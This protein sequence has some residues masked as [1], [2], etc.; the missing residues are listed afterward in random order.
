MPYTAF[1]RFV[2]WCRFR[3]ARPHI[4]PGSR[5]C[6]IG[7]GLDARFLRYLK[8]HIRLGLGL[9]YQPSPRSAN[10]PVVVLTDITSGFPVRSGSFDH[11]VM[12]AVLEHLA[13]PEAVL[14]EAHR[15]LAPGGSLVMTWPNATVD[16][17]LDV[18]HRIRVVSDEME[19]EQHEQ[20]ISLERLETM[21]REI[22]FERLMHRTFE[23][24][25]N[26]LLVAH[27]SA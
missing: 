10:G 25:L 11:A 2:A 18:L 12:L 23:L 27:K 22:G 15:I 24:G 1:D 13:R 19:S 21:L 4:R 8:G 5:L 17:I 26:N 3:A 7:C 6:D 16:P 9:D 20:R 14:R